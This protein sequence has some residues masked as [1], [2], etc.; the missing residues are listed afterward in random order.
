[1]AL[2]TAVTVSSM[3]QLDL[4]DPPPAAHQTAMQK[5]TVA[6][7]HPQPLSGHT[8]GGLT[9]SSSAI[10]AR[11]PVTNRRAWCVRGDCRHWSG[12]RCAHPEAVSRP[13][14]RRGR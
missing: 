7:E 4:F 9:L 6:L 10:P 2:R 8:D 12:G 14:R 3:Q 13:R 1:M 11:C 5:Q